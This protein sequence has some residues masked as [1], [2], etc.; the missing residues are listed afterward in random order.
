MQKRSLKAPK[1][2][3]KINPREIRMAVKSLHIIPGSREDWVVTTTGIAPVR[4][5]FST[6]QDAVE[7]GK[8]IARQ[9][10]TDLII[11]GRDGRIQHVDTYPS[12]RNHRSGSNR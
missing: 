4:E 12:D 7:R 8:T 3:G 10:K 5:R 11:H 9:K 2:V 6:K 1:K